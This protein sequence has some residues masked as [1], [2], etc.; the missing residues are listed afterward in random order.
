MTNVFKSKYDIKKEVR[1]GE[2]FIEFQYTQ[3][4]EHNFIGRWVKYGHQLDLNPS[5]ESLLCDNCF[6]DCNQRYKYYKEMNLRSSKRSYQVRDHTF[7]SDLWPWER[8]ICQSQNGCWGQAQRI[9]DIKRKFN[10]FQL[11][12]SKTINGITETVLDRQYFKVERECPSSST[13]FYHWGIGMK[14]RKPYFFWPNFLL[15]EP[16]NATYYFYVC[17]QQM[18]RLPN[19]FQNIPVCSRPYQYQTPEYKYLMTMKIEIFREHRDLRQ[20]P[21]TYSQLEK[22]NPVGRCYLQLYPGAAAFVCKQFVWLKN[23]KYDEEEY[24]HMLPALTLFEE[25]PKPQANWIA[26]HYVEENE[27]F[28][29]GYRDGFGGPITS[30]YVRVHA[31][32]PYFS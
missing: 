27:C 9:F 2:R 11:T 4:K 29:P 5:T 20:S 16:K 24:K 26:S 22:H 19:E 30:Y 3:F 10:R 15:N 1:I 25:P 14:T 31:L 13:N 8:C 18:Q 21:T 32:N 28:I 23:E 17:L 6:Q 12:H 7:S